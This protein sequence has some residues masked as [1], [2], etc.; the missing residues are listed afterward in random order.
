MDFRANEDEIY[1]DINTTIKS[2]PDG[3]KVTH[4]KGNIRVRE[5]GWEKDIPIKKKRVA[6]KKDAEQKSRLDNLQRTKQQVMDLVRCNAS[7]WKSFVTLTFEENIT[8]LTKANLM[9]HN[10]TK[11]VR[12]VFPDFK[13]LGVPEMQKRG[14]WHYHLFTNLIPGGNL[15]P[16]QSG[17]EKMYDVK[18]WKHGF[19]S[20]FNLDT[21]DKNFRADKYITKYMMKDHGRAVLFGRKRFLRS[22]NLSEP[23]KKSV[24]LNDE[25]Y[26]ALKKH[27]CKDAKLVKEK[28]VISGN[29]YCPDFDSVDIIA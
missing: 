14:A 24:F 1:K 28:T 29:R 2:F 11:A 9:F 17:K 26:H 21:T 3:F 5:K 7:D 20:V 25:E 12:R 8:D 6:C 22:Y 19:C 27:L 15:C 18:Y 10:W 4:Y 16:L 13:Y 23:Q